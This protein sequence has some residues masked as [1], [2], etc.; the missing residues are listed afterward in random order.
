MTE[1]KTIILDIDGVLNSTR[2]WHDSGR[3]LPQN[4]AGAI[5]PAAV[6]RLNTIVLNTGA[7]VVLSSSWRRLGL[8]V[9]NEMLRQRGFTSHLIDAT[10]L[11]TCPCCH[12][13]TERPRDIEIADWLDRR[14]HQVG[15]IPRTAILDDDIPAWSYPYPGSR[16]F[17][18][19]YLDGLTDDHVP[20]VIEWL[21]GESQ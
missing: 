3:H 5:D 10:P 11:V 20:V 4:Q 6:E 21:N 16:L 8:A 14:V 9:V 12:H 1:P 18:T 13:T 19:N 15:A 7:K 17:P 2:Y